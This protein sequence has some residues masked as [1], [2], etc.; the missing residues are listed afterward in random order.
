MVPWCVHEKEEPKTGK[1][2]KTRDEVTP[3]ALVGVV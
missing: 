3:N 2:L 1:S